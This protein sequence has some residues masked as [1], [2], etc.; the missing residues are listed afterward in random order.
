MN[1]NRYL[2]PAIS[3]IMLAIL[4]PIYWISQFWV[5][6]SDG[7]ET[8]YMNL[9]R[10][11]PSDLVFLIIGVLN[12]YVYLA[13][14]RFLNDR[15]AFSGADIPIT[16]I[17]IVVAVYT[18]GSLATDTL[19]HFFGDN[20]QLPWHQATLNGNT[21]AMLVSTFVFGVLDI[22]LGVFLFTQAR[23]FSHVLKAF[24]VIIIIQ[25]AFELTVVFGFLA[26]ALFPVALTLLAI[27]FV[28]QPD[29]L[30]VV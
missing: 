25:G 28:R 22:L 13:F 1:D 15:H 24:A 30:D 29:E 16:L 8:L 14:K 3:A 19:M 11:N 2:A 18:F 17:V 9:T 23:N 5:V 7:G 26:F 6:G 27:L 12:I 4:F 21:V 20:L 10:L